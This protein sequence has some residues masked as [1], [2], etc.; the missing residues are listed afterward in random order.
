M[1]P[2]IDQFEAWR[3]ALGETH[4]V[5]P[6]A[7]GAETGFAARATV[8]LLG[9]TMVSAVGSEG[10]RFDRSARRARVD[11][12]DHYTFVMMRE[13]SWRG[14]VGGREIEVGPGEVCVLDLARSANVMSTDSRSLWIIAPR[15]LVDAAMPPADLHGQVLNGVTGGLLAD[16]MAVLARRIGDI[17]ATSAGHVE[18]ATQALIAASLAPSAERAE[19]AAPAIADTL[20]QKARHYIEANLASP[21][22]GPVPLCRA[23]GVSRSALYR[24]FEPAGGVAAYIQARRLAHVRARLADPRET[25]RISELAYSYGFVS[26]AHFSRAFRRA[27]DVSASEVRAHAQAHAEPVGAVGSIR[28]FHS[29]MRGS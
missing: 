8:H 6:P 26:E 29:W 9:E 28:V 21:E 14:E 22:L 2:R 19:R 20:T 13:G 11:G 4:E 25:R 5:V 1:L 17:P 7:R 16:Y 24:L 27:F 23:L 12:R 3:Q 18:R 10:S 15:D